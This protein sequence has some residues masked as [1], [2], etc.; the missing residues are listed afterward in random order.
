MNISIPDNVVNKFKEIAPPNTD[1]ESFVIE[2]VSN[3]VDELEA[4]REDPFLKYITNTKNHTVNKD[5]LTDISVNH[6]KYLY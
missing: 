6:D 3:Y 4:R 5:G 2:T 1:I